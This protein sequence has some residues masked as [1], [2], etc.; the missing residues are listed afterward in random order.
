MQVEGLI[1]LKYHFAI[2]QGMLPWQPIKAAKSVFFV[3]Q[4]SLSWCHSEM[5][6]NIAILISTD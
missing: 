1:N 4:T 5:V 6:C 2:S 3:D